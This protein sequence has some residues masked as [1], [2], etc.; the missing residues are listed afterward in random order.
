[1]SVISEQSRSVDLEKQP[2]IA[3]T[4]ARNGKISIPFPIESLPMTFTPQDRPA[5]IQPDQRQVI[6]QKV[7]EA[8]G[9]RPH[10]VFQLGQYRRYVK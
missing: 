5:I 10:N 2:V 9:N 1:M 8:T 6:S 4:H 7:F 3:R